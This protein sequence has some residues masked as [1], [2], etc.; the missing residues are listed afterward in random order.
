MPEKVNFNLTKVQKKQD[1]DALH[2]NQRKGHIHGY[3]NVYKFLDKD[4]RQFV[5]YAPS[6]DTSGYGETEEKAT[7]MIKE[8]LTDIFMSF[9]K[10]PPDHLSAELLKFGW[11]KHSLRNKDFS[12]PSVGLD[13]NKLEELNVDKNHIERFALVA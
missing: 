7:F 8:S 4:T 10:M 6:L 13:E 9:I 1:F 5:V 2:I 12:N 11:K 3:I